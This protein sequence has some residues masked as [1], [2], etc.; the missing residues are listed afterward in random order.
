[1][2]RTI[3]LIVA[4]LV[5]SP[6][7]S[8]G[9]ELLVDDFEDGD[10]ISRQGL[11]WMIIAD[12][13]MGGGSRGDLEIVTDEGNAA[14][15]LVG[16]LRRGGSPVGF[17]GAWTAVGADGLS[18]DLSAY[19]GVRLRARAPSGRYQLGLRRAGASTNFSTPVEIG[20]DWTDIEVPFSALRP[21]VQ[22]GTAG[23]DWSA[24]D[25]TWVGVSSG[26]RDDASVRLEID[27]LSFFGGPAAERAPSSA[28]ASGSPAATMQLTEAAS[29]RDLSWQPLAKEEAGDAQRPNLPDAVE[30]SWA[31]GP[32]DHVWFRVRLAAAPPERWMGINIAIDTNSDPNDGM[33]WW[34]SNSGFHFDQLITAYLTRTESYWM[35][36]AG[37]ATAEQVGQMVM[38][39]ISS[40]V[41]A[42]IDRSEPAFLVGIP[43]RDLPDTGTVRLIA[44]VG[45][46]MINNDDLPNESAV[47]LT[48]PHES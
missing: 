30:L 2:S 9:G 31:T 42:A 18:R 37:L 26:G 35:G 16:E 11:A 15:E 36:A 34:G 19:E 23:P 14:L 7:P 40:N 10:L 24:S 32:G 17:I 41:R 33:A 47:T 29:L 44:T 25:V 28:A 1:M 5:L 38:N 22:P 39:G 45:S 20:V 46:S 3:W 21:L 13:V 43:R 8:W 27:R 4:L 6:S 48:L 12:D